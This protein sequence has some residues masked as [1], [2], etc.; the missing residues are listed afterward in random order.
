MAW[1]V[2]GV[3]SFRLVAPLLQPGVVGPIPGTGCTVPQLFAAE[4]N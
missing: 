1:I 2:L 4:G 3:S